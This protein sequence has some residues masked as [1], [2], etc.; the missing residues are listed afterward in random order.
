VANRTS[1]KDRKAQSTSAT[2]VDAIIS[3]S[4]NSN[5]VY[6]SADDSGEKSAALSKVTLYVRPEQVL[7]IEEI[8]LAERKRTGKKPDKSDLMQEALDLL[9]QKYSET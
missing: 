5:G 9:I 7:A 8:Q 3:S 2:G 6:T 4:E 1:L